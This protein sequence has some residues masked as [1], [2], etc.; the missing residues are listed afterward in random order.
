MQADRHRLRYEDPELIND[1]DVTIETIDGSSP[2]LRLEATGRL[3]GLPTTEDADVWLPG[4]YKFD[5]GRGEWRPDPE[6]SKK[7]GWDDY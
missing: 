7:M 3:D 2:Q 4:I 1:L 6:S 5:P